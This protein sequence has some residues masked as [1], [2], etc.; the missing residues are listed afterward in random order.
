MKNKI[1]KYDFIIV[2]GGLIGS[3]T[4]LALLQKGKTVAVFEKNN[5]K[6]NDNRTLA[7]NANS[8]E[9]LTNLGLW[10]KLSFKSEPIKK[11]IINDFINT[12]DLFFENKHEIMGSVI[13]NKDLLKIAQKELIKKKLLFK[14]IKLNLSI[15]KENKI[16]II[17]KK[18]F[19]FK[20]II[21]CLGKNFTETDKLK[22]YNFESHH[23]SFVGF[24][25][26]TKNHQNHAYESFTNLGPLA[27]LPAPKKNK[28]YST[29]IFS[30]K[31]ALNQKQLYQLLNKYFKNTHGNISLQ[32][33]INNFPIKPHLTKSIQNNYLLVGD[34]LRSIHPVAGQGWNLGI[35]DIQELIRTTQN[36]SLND[37]NFNDIYFSRRLPENIGFLLFT[38]LINKFYE[39]NNLFYRL[40]IKFGFQSFLKFGFL[41]DIFIKKAMGRLN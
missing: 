5:L 13:Y 30:S 7:V 1:N 6:I 8:R 24:F 15:L 25:N 31:T 38:N 41:R 4:A 39:N 20:K 16:L 27:V 18:K 23:R 11:I 33:E 10:Q 2:G 28:K 40:F 3:L 29:F 26:H 17:D 21:L 14:N 22:K 36:I 35:N 19:I 34:T 37:Q 9:F 32:N 12:E